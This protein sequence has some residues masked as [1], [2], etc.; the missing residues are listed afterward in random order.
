MHHDVLAQQIA[1]KE[2]PGTFD[3]A[4]TYNHEM[5]PWLL[6]LGRNNGPYE[7]TRGLPESARFFCNA[8]N[9]R[10][11][12]NLMHDS[13]TNCVLALRL[14]NCPTFPDETLDVCVRACLCV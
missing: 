6:Q 3:Q 13:A 5:V 14:T 9:T 2:A 7:S 12:F 11:H 1:S 8:Q 10:G 4:L